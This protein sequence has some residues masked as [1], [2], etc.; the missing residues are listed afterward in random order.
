M[1][2]T[3]RAETARIQALAITQARAAA[4]SAGAGSKG[5]RAQEAGARA[6][7][8]P[9]GEAER[10]GGGVIRL[11]GLV[12]RIE[13]AER[14]AARLA[15]EL[16]AERCGAWPSPIGRRTSPRPLLL[17]CAPGAAPRGCLRGVLRAGR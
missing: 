14:D 10:A 4:V 2:R 6:R 16:H 5:A 17:A 1:Q 8:S 7:R 11:G 13:Q 12:H 3:R 9:L 15:S